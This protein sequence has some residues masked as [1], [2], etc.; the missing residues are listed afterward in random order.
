MGSHAAQFLS[1]KDQKNKLI[2]LKDIGVLATPA[3]QKFHFFYKQS[4]LAYFLQL[5]NVNY[6]H[7]SKKYS[8][9]F[10]N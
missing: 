6:A 9:L 2:T 10:N 7:F 3:I 4:F 1:I 5:V 8:I